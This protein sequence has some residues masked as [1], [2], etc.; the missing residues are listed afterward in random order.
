MAD[1]QGSRLRHPVPR[2]LAT[3]DPDD[4]EVTH[5]AVATGAAFTCM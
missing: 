5:H 3:L 1:H 4:Y 2:R